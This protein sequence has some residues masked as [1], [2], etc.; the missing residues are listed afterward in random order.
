MPL[1]PAAESAPTRV[2]ATS[3]TL[4]EENHEEESIDD[5]MQKLMQRVR[6]TTGEPEPPARPAPRVEPS[7][8]MT[9]EERPES[10][11]AKSSTGAEA[12]PA[13]PLRPRSALPPKPINMDAL[14][15]VANLSAKSAIGQ[16]ARRTMVR[17]MYG[18][19]FL[20]AVALAVGVGLFWLWKQYGASEITLY[21]SAAAIVV[22]L[23]FGLQYVSLMIGRMI[24]AKAARAHDRQAASP[25]MD[26]KG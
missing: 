24:V 6:A 17:T 13:E 15:E 9:T 12:K 1:R 7:A 21:S 18:K 16:H 11:S 25:D 22:A 23:M 8:S 19:L 5:Y 10:E 26:N 2:T 3:A 14:R 4:S 20:T